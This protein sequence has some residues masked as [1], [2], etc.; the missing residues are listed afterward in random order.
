VAALV[1]RHNYQQAQGLSLAE[2]QA[3]SHLGIHAAFIRDLERHSN[4][5][6]KLEGLP[7]EE[8]ILKRLADNR[9]LTRPELSVLQAY[10]KILFTSDLLS[11]DIPD[12]PDVGDWL[13]HYFPTPLRKKYAKEIGQHRLHR[14][15][16]ATVLSN[17]MVNRMGATFVKSVMDKTN[18]SCADV[19]KA[20][21]VVR[22]AFELHTLWAEIEALDDVVPA[23]V[24]LNAMLEIVRMMERETVWFLTRLGH[25]PDISRDKRDYGAGIATLR[26]N[27]EKIA[28]P[29]L[30]ATIAERLKKGMADGLPPELARRIALIPAMG[31][32][33]DILRIAKD[34]GTPVPLAARSYFEIGD[35][36]RLPW[37]RQQARMLPAN[38]RWT[39]SALIGLVEGLHNV[40][41]G[42]TAR[43]LMDSSKGSKAGVEKKTLSGL[44]E[45]WLETKG[46]NARKLEPMIAELHQAGTLD[47][48]M[49]I[50]A[51]QKLRQI[52][53]E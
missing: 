47:L 20:W 50:L 53:G 37:L 45:N 1:L 24:Q 42:L 3:A 17:D 35:H 44:V 33:C 8:T 30:A 5:N 51:E 4:L 34:S 29:A 21:L 15:I 48:S 38:D 6:R 46:A 31:A 7:D 32:S 16:V 39:A 9:G 14:E 27:L 19:A 28:T 49:L 10:A 25:S 41:S 18:A 36:F 43:V 13:I 12:N 22:D 2:M 23:A 52:Y 11:T 26:D 40:Q